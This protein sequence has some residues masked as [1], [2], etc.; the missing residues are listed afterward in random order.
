MSKN[1]LVTELKASVSNDALLKVGEFFID[2]IARSTVDENSSSLL[3]RNN[4]ENITVNAI[5]GA[6]FAESY[7][8]LSDPAKRLTSISI[9]ANTSKMLYVGN[10]NGR[11]KISGKYTMNYLGYYN[12]V[13]RPM[14]ML[15]LSDVKYSTNLAILGISWCK[16]SLSN[17]LDKSL[18]YLNIVGDDIYSDTISF[19]GTAFQRFVLHSNN[20][21]GNISQLPSMPNLSILDISRCTKITGNVADLAKLPA[22]CTT[23]IGGTVIYGTLEGLVASFV[24]SHSTSTYENKNIYTGFLENVT[25]GGNNYTIDVR[26]FLSWESKTKIYILHGAA[27]AGACTKVLCKGYTTEEAASKWPGKT[28]VMVDA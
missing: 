11:L 3:L 18:Q 8:D 26:G 10:S 1:C 15:D 20:V 16:G 5:E 12:D 21:S 13:T 7:A 22:S 14:M 19:T 28:V 2:I 6:Y 4:T 25:F 23:N 9:D 24:D 27:T 17:I